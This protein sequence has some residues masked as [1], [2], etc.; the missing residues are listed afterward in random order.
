MKK[1]TLLIL[2][3]LISIFSYA[4]DFEFDFIPNSLDE[5]I[6]ENETYIKPHFLGN[7]IARK[8]KLV[9]LAYKW[10]DPPTAT[11]LSPLI[12]IEKQPIYFAIK[13]VLAPKFY[14][15]KI[16]NKEISKEEAIEQLSEILDVA[17]MI[18]YQ[19][20][21]AFENAVRNINAE[22][23]LDVFKNKIKLIYF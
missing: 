6:L 15:N 22:T 12:Q 23:V 17:I 16:K 18:R 5:A 21:E 10:E 14:K 13:K 11:R 3:T 20:T 1:I 19:E 2:F 8:A 4:Q 7:T 9:E